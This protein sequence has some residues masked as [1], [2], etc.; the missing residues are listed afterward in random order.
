MDKILNY[1]YSSI[2]NNLIL[3]KK[4]RKLINNILDIYENIF[5]PYP[6]KC[7][8]IKK[9]PP[10]KI[11][12]FAYGGTGD[13]AY[14]SA[15]TSHLKKK[16]PD[17]K[18]FYVINQIERLK[19]VA[20]LDKNIDKIIPIKFPRFFTFNFFEK[21]KKNFT[22]DVSLIMNFYPNLR[23]LMP[24][25]NFI[26]YPFF[27]FRD[28]PLKSLPIP[29]LY[30]NFRIKRQNYIFLNFEALT[31]NF[32][33]N[34]LNEKVVIDLTKY[35]LEKFPEENFIINKFI[36]FSYIKL[37]NYPNLKIFNDDYKNL[38]KVASQSKLIILS[39]SG[40]VDVLAALNR[41]LPMFTIYPDVLYPGKNGAPFIKVFGLKE[42]YHSNKIEEF[43]YNKNNYFLLKQKLLDFLKYNLKK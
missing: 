39:R 17:C 36:N 21:I 41:N 18:I 40:L 10:K 14:F 2:K 32:D 13:I 6:N 20:L 12:L 4:L 8:E 5:H 7:L 15:F 22:F 29:K 38:V 9:W 42:I 30:P 27:L 31:F 23:Y 11:L 3:E 33:E 43:T 25:L 19:F 35:I 26:Y 1:L 24:N 34:F 16:F 37:K 28:I